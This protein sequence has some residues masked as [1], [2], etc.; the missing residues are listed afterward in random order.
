METGKH[1]RPEEADYLR[2]EKIPKEIK[3]PSID[4]KLR[5]DCLALLRPY[6]KTKSRAGIYTLD[7]I[8]Y[9]LNYGETLEHS[10]SVGLIYGAICEKF[11]SP[12]LVGFFEGYIAGL[13]H[14]VGKS[15]QRELFTSNKIYNTAER[16]MA[17]DHVYFTSDILRDDY[18]TLKWLVCGHHLY[19]QPDGSPYPE[20]YR[21]KN[22]RMKSLQM[23]LAIA[24]KASS[25]TE[26]RPE[27]S[28]EERAKRQ[29]FEGLFGNID[30]LK[31]WFKP[32]HSFLASKQIDYVRKIIQKKI[33][34][35]PYFPEM[36]IPVDDPFAKKLIILGNLKPDGSRLELNFLNSHLL[37]PE[38]AK[39]L[40][41]LTKARHNP[42]LCNISFESVA[43]EREVLY[44]L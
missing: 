1:Y 28:V 18:P 13:V 23:A 2:G 24:D 33:V 41:K 6:S 8:L 7:T 42:T 3:D 10:I 29:T 35:T 16:D 39:L 26:F 22:K 19:G 37:G 34:F 32:E 38:L 27:L 5:R 20:N 11:Y 4:V 25:S 15:E 21:E 31:E 14:D 17:K 40:T 30:R 12:S 9:Y 43:D 44:R 36:A